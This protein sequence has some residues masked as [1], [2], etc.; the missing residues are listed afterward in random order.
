MN[1]NKIIWRLKFTGMNR[2][3]CDGG[4]GFYPALGV[5]TKDRQPVLCESGWHVTSAEHIYEY[6]GNGRRCFIVQVAGDHEG[7]FK[8]DDKESWQ[9]MR[10]LYELTTD[11]M[12]SLLNGMVKT[13]ALKYV[14]P[15]AFRLYDVDYRA[16]EAIDAITCRLFT[17]CDLADQYRDQRAQGLYN[18]PLESLAREVRTFSR[19]RAMFEKWC[20]KKIRG[21]SYAQS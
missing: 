2:R 15:A 14:T 20:E 11:D 17:G 5:W 21:L 12:V 13:R 19:S 1:P 9:R 18:E 7:G 3:P 10:L 4:T 6:S 16:E 8:H